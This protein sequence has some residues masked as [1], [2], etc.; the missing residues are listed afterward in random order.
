[1]KQITLKQWFNEHS[2]EEY[3]E[4][5]GKAC[6]GQ[7]E[8]IFIACGFPEV[9]YESL[10]GKKHICCPNHKGK[11]ESN[12][13]AL[14]TYKGSSFN[15]I[16][17]GV[18]NT[19]GVKQN[20]FTHLKWLLKHEEMKQTR[21]H[22]MTSMGWSWGHILNDPRLDRELSEQELLQEKEKRRQLEARREE[23]RR[24]QRILRQKQDEKMSLWCDEVHA[25]LFAGCVPLWHKDAEPARLY[26]KSRG[27]KNLWCNRKI[28]S[29]VQYSPRSGVY[30]NGVYYGDHG[31][32]VVKMT[33][34]Q[35][36]IIYPHRTVID[37]N[38]NRVNLD[39]GSKLKGP[40]RPTQEQT[41]RA[42]RFLSP[43][44]VQGVC[45]GME[46]AY[47]LLDQGLDFPV[48]AAS[49]AISL[50]GWEPQDG[51]EVVCIFEDFDR[52]SERYTNE[53]GHG[54]AAGKKL[55]D[56]LTSKGYLVI[57]VTPDFDIPDG[58]KSVDWN[59][60]YANFAHEYFPLIVVKWKE[61]ERDF[62]KRSLD[63]VCKKYNL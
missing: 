57:R 49:D 3:K 59:D 39:C 28:A 48:D 41:N 17:A 53:G 14:P 22:I 18:C 38:G 58:S 27:I 45:E 11:T 40:K 15:E 5:W 9:V 35:G 31:S 19:C 29:T 36:E 26:L 7:W 2:K 25:E 44:V 23:D 34:G 32:I 20:G 12:Y 63:Y 60:V 62:Q 24:Q 50:E 54:V 51:V 21:K 37:S 61:F 33:N 16:G 46:V 10:A 30:A 1:M 42:A 6:N 52:P 13:R 43:S 55:A 56:K 8:A 4:A 47:S